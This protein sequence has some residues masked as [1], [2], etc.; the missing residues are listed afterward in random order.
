MQFFGR[1]SAVVRHPAALLV[2][3]CLIRGGVLWLRSE[4]LAGDPDGYRALA[5]NLLSSGVFG[6][7]QVPTAYRPPLYPL[8]LAGCL[9]LTTHSIFAVAALHGVLGVATAVLTVVLGRQCRLGGFASL[10]GLLVACDPILLHQSTLVMTET[11]AAFLAAAA[12]VLVT[13]AAE[14]RSSRVAALAGVVVGLA[15][16]CR[17]TFLLWLATLAAGLAWSGGWRM[18]VRQAG[19]ML[20]AAALVLLPW[21]V[22]NRVQLGRPIVTTTHGG[23]TLLLGNNADYYAHLA[24]APWGA[25]WQADRLDAELRAT[26]SRDE[27]ANDRREYALAWQTLRNQPGMFA[28]ACLARVGRFWGILPHDVAARHAGQTEPA[29]VRG[30]RYGVAAW[31]LGVFGLALAAIAS[32]EIAVTRPPWLWGVL[33]A[34]SFT[35][36][37]ALYWSDLRMR[38]PLVPLIS[39]MAASGAQWI[40]RRAGTRPAATWRSPGLNPEP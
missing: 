9:K 17:P 2:V 27:L 24:R 18:C 6:H 8:L 33:L 36:A 22:R 4:Q 12:L 38:A 11:L 28:R 5:D 3:V 1:C 16:L 23:Y 40:R 32:R 30:L 35:A 29:I 26:R 20:V 7:G 34:V 25:V 13:A 21:A 19:A 37:H 15:V 39:V 10:A 31:Y 14:R